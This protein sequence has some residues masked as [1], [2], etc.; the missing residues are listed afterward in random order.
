[1]GARQVPAGG[2]RSGACPGGRDQPK[3]GRSGEPLD[4]RLPFEGTRPP[5]LRLQINEP[6]RKSAARVSRRFPSRVGFEPLGQVVGDACVERAIGAAE[7]VDEPAGGRGASQSRSPG[8]FAARGAGQGLGIV[9]GRLI[10]PGAVAFSPPGRPARWQESPPWSPPP[11]G[12][13]R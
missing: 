13:S 4:R 11:N 10:V 9:I 7:E 2:A 12:A 5:R 8:W 1:M 6:D 3:F